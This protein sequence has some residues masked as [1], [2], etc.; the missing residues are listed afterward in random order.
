MQPQRTSIRPHV[1]RTKSDLRAAVAA[2]GRFGRIIAHGFKTRAQGCGQIDRPRTRHL[3]NNTPRTLHT[4][5]KKW[6]L[7]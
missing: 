6:R 4:N 3:A 5:A 7:H 2:D 1:D